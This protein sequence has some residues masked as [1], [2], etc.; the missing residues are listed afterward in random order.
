MGFIMATSDRWRSL[1]RN[2]QD[3]SESLSDK[4]LHQWLCPNT[5]V[6][7]SS[8]ATGKSLNKVE[9]L[10]IMWHTVSKYVFFFRLIDCVYTRYICKIKRSIQK[11]VWHLSMN[12]RIA[13]SLRIVNGRCQ[14]GTSIVEVDL[15]QADLTNVRDWLACVFLLHLH[16]LLGD[17]SMEHNLLLHIRMFI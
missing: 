10:D 14:K 4:I 6:L 5:W 17:V 1:W 8:S 15:L 16:Q 11:H 13:S 3:G 9:L 12:L 2:T 7:I